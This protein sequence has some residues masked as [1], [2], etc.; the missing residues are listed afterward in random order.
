MRRIFSTRQNGAGR[1]LF[2]IRLIR[3][4]GSLLSRYLQKTAFPGK[5]MKKDICLGIDH[6][7]ASFLSDPFLMFLILHNSY[8]T[9]HFC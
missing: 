5:T 1:G 4:C 7:L 6:F 8:S 9:A 3:F 2:L